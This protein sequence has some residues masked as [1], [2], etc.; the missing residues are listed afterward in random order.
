MLIETVFRSE[1][2]PAADR[3][4]CYRELMN[5]AYAP[6]ELSSGH[7]PDFRAHQR[8]IGLGAVS[9]W[10]GEFEPLLL[11][12]TPKLIRQSDPEVYQ[13]TLVLKGSGKHSLGRQETIC[14]AY[15][16]HSNDSSR[17]SETRTGQGRTRIIGVEFPKTQLPLPRS[18]ADQVIGRHMSAQDG[19]GALLAQFLIQLTRDTGQYTPDDGPRLGTVA[20]DLTAALFSHTFG[21]DTSLA[22]EAHRRTLTCASKHSSSSTCTTPP[23]PRVR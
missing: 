11:R 18:R 20:I 5:R 1:D 23:S 17:P 7:A 4:E 19:I 9:V 16:F 8:L 21:A 12:R 22:P 6:M 15:E 13:L 10:P 3:F 2:V 14:D